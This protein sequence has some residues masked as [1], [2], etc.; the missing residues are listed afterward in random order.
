MRKR[1]PLENG[2]MAKLQIWFLVVDTGCRNTRFC[3]AEV[4]VAGS[5]A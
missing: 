3:L 4:L 1:R 5:P 2:W